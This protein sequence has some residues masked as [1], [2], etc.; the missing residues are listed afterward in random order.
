[1][2]DFYMYVAL[3]MVSGANLI[4]IFVALMAPKTPF[5]VHLIGFVGC[6]PLSA[7]RHLSQGPGPT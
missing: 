1:M 2:T 7:T 5:K 4:E 3:G 6:A